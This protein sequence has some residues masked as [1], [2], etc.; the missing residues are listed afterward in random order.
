M[1]Y[2]VTIARSYGSGGR[3][4]GIALANS[5]GI[6]YYG[7]ELWEQE[8][9]EDLYGKINSSDEN[10]SYSLH[11][12]EDNVN[13]IADDR[14]F[15]SQSKAILDKAKKGS[16]VFVG[17]C[18]DYVLRHKENVVKIY[19]YST[20]RECIR[21]VCRL[22]SLNPDEASELITSMNRSRGEYYKQFTG[23]VWNDCSH[24]DLCINSSQITTEQCIQIIKDYLSIRFNMKL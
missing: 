4:I 22:Y 18:A 11:F 1:S 9:H 14:I 19:I 23:L 8:H 2:M 13:F 17:R 10:L 15:N 24:Y 16:C 12:A 5:L 3:E 21:R 7:K 20:P 6:D